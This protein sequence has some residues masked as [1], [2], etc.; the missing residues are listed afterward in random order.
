ME[1]V[2]SHL[3]EVVGNDLDQVAVV[4]VG[5]QLGRAG[6]EQVDD[7]AD[8]DDD[9]VGSDEL[10]PPPFGWQPRV[11]GPRQLFWRR[12]EI[13]IPARQPCRGFHAGQR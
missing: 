10:S 11:G 13:W 7:D 1:V 2:G 8:V 3:L 9:G 5:D 12:C 4:V 6:M